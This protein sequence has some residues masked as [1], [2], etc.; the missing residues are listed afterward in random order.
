MKIMQII[1][2]ATTGGAQEVVKQLIK[3]AIKEG[4]SCI[5]ISHKTGDLWKKLEYLPLKR[6]PLA[7]LVNPISPV[8][9]FITFW[10][11][12]WIFLKEK[13][14][15]VHL[16]SAKA[17]FLGRMALGFWKKKILYTQ[18]GFETILKA[19]RKTLFL[20][21]IVKNLCFKQ[22]TVCFYDE[23]KIRETFSSVG[24]KG[25]TT[26]YNGIESCK[27]IEKFY[28]PYYQLFQTIQSQKKKIILCLARFDTTQNQ[29][30]KYKLNQPKN[31]PL[32]V[33]VA[34]KLIDKNFHFIWMGNIGKSPIKLPPNIS[35]LGDVKEGRSYL[36]LADLFLLLSHYEGLPISIL[37][38]FSLKTPV[39]A[40][41][42]GGISE[43]IE[44]GKTGF[45]ENSEK[46]QNIAQKI[47]IIFENESLLRNITKNAYSLWQ[48]KYCSS[49]MWKNYKKVYE[50][51]L[52]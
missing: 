42:V 21:K 24:M 47:E 45:L 29:E 39:L 37:E 46:A 43:L 15:I 40:S 52:N 12:L 26:I 38:A 9:D 49:I 36:P 19:H 23:K 8:K 3:E 2:L 33:E 48:K 30:G 41:Q 25:V 28:L 51:I 34:Y 4:H 7:S 27:T 5:L 50:E 13:P 17:G 6:Y 35:L 32:T 22:I 44:E 16:H 14:D 10:K 11:I 31:F 1:T 20:E 18:H